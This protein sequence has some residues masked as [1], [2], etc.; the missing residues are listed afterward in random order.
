M[1]ER[2]AGCG[3]YYRVSAACLSAGAIS[4]KAMKTIMDGCTAATHVA[5]ALSDVA[6]I[7][8][9]T[10]IAEMGQTAQKWGLID[11]RRNLMGR[12]MDVHEME[13]E[14]GAAGATHGAARAGALSTTFTA[15]Q[16]LVLMFP[17]MFKIAGEMLPVV[18]HVGTRSLASHALSIYGDHQDVMACRATGFTILASAS[19]QETMDL[20]LVAHLAAIDGSLPVLHMMDGWR[21]SNEMATIDVIPYSDMAP[22]VNWHKVE[23]FR[24]RASNP[25]TPDLHG[26]A[27]DP[28]VFFQNRE[29]CN[30]AYQAFPAIVSKAMERVGAL[31][32]RRYN[33]V[34]YHGAPDA[35]RVIVA[36][37]SATLVAREAVDLLNARGEKTGI[38]TVRLFHPFPIDEFVNAI[39]AT[40]RQIA[41]LNRTKEPGAVGEPLYLEALSA[42]CRAGRSPQVFNGRYG[43]SSKDFTPSMAASVFAAMKNNTLTPDFTVGINDDVT[44]LS[45]DITDII[46]TTREGTYQAVFYGIGADG[47]VGSTKLAASIIGN[48]DGLYAQAFFEYSAKKSGG[49][50]IS[51]LRFGHSPVTSAYG[52]EHADYVGCNKSTYV[53]RFNMLENIKDGGT[54]VLNSPWGQAQMA[55]QLP[56][57][58]KQS[59]ARKKLKFYSIDAVKIAA[60]AGLGNRINTVMMTVFLYLSRVIPFEQAKAA[61]EERV[62]QTYMHE[63]GEVVARNLKAIANAIVGLKEIAYPE[64]WAQ[65]PDDPAETPTGNDFIDRIARPC[66]HFKDNELPV[67]LFAPDGRIPAGTTVWEKRTIADNVPRWDPDKCVQCTE[68]SLVCSHAAI[69]P[70]LLTS[71][72]A[73]AAPKEF[74]TL[75]AKGGEALRPYRYRIQVFARDCTGCASCVTICPG[76]ALTMMPVMPEVAAQMPLEDYAVNHVGYKE[77]VIDRFT[78]NGSQ[79]MQPLMEFSG[80]CGGCGETPY[81][82]LLTQ[83]FGPRLLIA[84]AT[85]CSSIWG[86]SYPSNPFCTNSKGHG[87]AWANSL[88]ED[89]AEFAYG[90][91]VAVDGRRRRLQ[92]AARELVAQTDVTEAV[93]DA[94]GQW[95]DSFS[96]PEKSQTAG[97]ALVQAISTAALTSNAA[98]AIVNDSD[99]LGSKS[100]WAVGGDGW[101][102]DIGFAGLDHVL[103]SG[104][105]VN[106][107]VLDTECYSNTG[108]Q[109]S[110]ATPMASTA[111]Y[112]P[113]GKSTYKKDLARMMM[114][115]GTVYVATVALGANYGYTIKVL[116]EAEAFDGPSI[117]IAYCPCI[118]HGIRSGMSHSI[119]E[120]REAVAAGYWPL[121]SYN[122]SLAQPLSV[123]SEVP[124]N[125]AL[126]LAFIN[127]EDRYVDLKMIDP[128]RAAKLQPELQKRLYS[129]ITRLKGVGSVP[130]VAPLS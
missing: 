51:Q 87:P 75:P 24:R 44:N 43:L 3:R 18:F 22:L 64:E 74:V 16:G 119:T 59:I 120:E 99:M 128:A 30:S 19:V 10:P 2:A 34:D 1:N 25:L 32:G 47:T 50:T 68:C 31:T 115:Y 13:S 89:N 69:R 36:I 39:P 126:T 4:R 33:L 94:A 72:E 106:V 5:F 90:M 23:E 62:R 17:N 65:L 117:V 15:S 125:P 118:N 53:T 61:L 35:D 45:V 14:L 109:T 127:G 48:T 27:Q 105:N 58:I 84:N 71:S 96:D 20:A 21:T 130:P 83:L 108:G 76:R 93:K 85:G 110:K 104:E 56:N 123:D 49:Y 81:V 28:G 70:F 46:D 82:K 41:V 121:M 97:D 63:G 95:L 9:I 79:F 57:A 101:A 55:L 107:L 52:I 73:D 29:A 112:S 60:D 78:V 66:Y 8:P 38:V 40:A 124:A 80:A 113:N 77:N 12:P 100:V 26:S 11:G 114:T 42:L 37:G 88:F 67:S 7:Y 116:Q 129:V 103:A 92:D 102:Y 54:F 111:K 91:K 122:P 86:G 6:T 98:N